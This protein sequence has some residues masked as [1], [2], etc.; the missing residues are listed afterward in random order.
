M[1]TRKD[2][3]GA[4]LQLQAVLRPH[5]SWRSCVA[6][7]ASVFRILMNSVYYFQQSFPLQG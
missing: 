4:K 6:S 5:D 7:A 1:V 2:T 3:N